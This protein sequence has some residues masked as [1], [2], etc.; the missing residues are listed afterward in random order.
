[1]NDKL[2]IRVHA[3]RGHVYNEVPGGQGPGHGEGGGMAPC[4]F[5]SLFFTVEGHDPIWPN[6]DTPML[7]SSPLF[8]ML[9]NNDVDPLTSL[10][11]AGRPSFRCSSSL[12]DD[13]VT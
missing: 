3:C 5:F 7:V 9:E 13:A 10:V 4:T 12:I 1:M 11:V 2:R 8:I 6:V